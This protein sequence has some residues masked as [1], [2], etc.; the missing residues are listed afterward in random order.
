MEA[1]VDIVV[2]YPQELQPSAV[3]ARLNRIATSALSFPSLFFSGF[4]SVIKNA[5]DNEDTV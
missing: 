4:Q 3:A 5:C 1:T 2:G